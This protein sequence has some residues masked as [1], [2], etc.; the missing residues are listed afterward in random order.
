MKYSAQSAGIGGAWVDKSKLTNGMRAKIVSETKPIPG[1]FKDQKT[2]EVKDQDVAKVRFE[3]LGDAVN[4][5]LNKP[6][7]AGLIDA[8]GE[9]SVNWQGHYLTVE[10]E[11]VRIGG[12]AV[13]ALYL[14][15]EGYKKID[16]ENGYAAVVKSTV[17]E[18][19]AQ[20]E[21][22]ATPSLKP[23]ATEAVPYP[24]ENINVD[25]IPF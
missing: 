13:T 5:N 4:V 21:H 16:D 18:N 6:T 3:G 7:I 25:D 9:D 17:T 23:K 24:E 8:F 11:K 22:P 12:K 19:V 20:P 2:G 15:P 10:L 14:L 1:N